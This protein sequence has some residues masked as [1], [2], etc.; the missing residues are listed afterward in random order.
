MKYSFPGEE[1]EGI[2]LDK[3]KVANAILFNAL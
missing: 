2:R 3:I 1:H